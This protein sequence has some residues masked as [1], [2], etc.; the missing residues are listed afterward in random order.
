[1]S[2]INLLEYLKKLGFD[3]NETY[4]VPKTWQK[5]NELSIKAHIKDIK[6]EFNKNNGD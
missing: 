1:M 6:Y 5:A 3:E 2:E 4:E